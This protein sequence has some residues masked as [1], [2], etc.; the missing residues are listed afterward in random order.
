MIQDDPA[1]TQLLQIQIFGSSDVCWKKLQAH[2]AEN[3][4]LLGVFEDLRDG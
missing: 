4:P 1:N 2:H 3:F